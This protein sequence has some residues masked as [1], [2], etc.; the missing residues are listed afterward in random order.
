MKIIELVAQQKAQSLEDGGGTK[1]E[2]QERL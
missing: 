2:I 1:S